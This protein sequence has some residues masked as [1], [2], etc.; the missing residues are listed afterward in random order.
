MSSVAGRHFCASHFVAATF[1][2]VAGLD[3]VAQQNSAT[4]LM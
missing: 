1:A 4:S 3:F 2:V